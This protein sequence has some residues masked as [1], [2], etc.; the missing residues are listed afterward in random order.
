MKFPTRISNDSCTL[1]DNIYINTHRHDFSVHPLINGLS[2]H[3][4]QITTLLHTLFPLLIPDPHFLFL[5]KLIVT[6][7]V[8]SH[9][10]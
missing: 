10:Y 5:G 7:L 3:D 6:L 1:I 4:G 9:L 8:N 2:D